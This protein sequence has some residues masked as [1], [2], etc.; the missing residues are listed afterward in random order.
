MALDPGTKRI[1]VALSDELGWTAQPL[2]TFERRTLAQD[3]AHIQQLVREHAV[4]EIV[5]GLPI[6]LNGELGPE[7]EGVKRFIH[8][9]EQSL[10]VP[11][12]AWDERLT[13]K[14]AE[15]LL[16]QA[17]VSRKKRRGVVDRVAAA[18]LLQSY[19]RSL[20]DEQG[21]FSAADAAST[22]TTADSPWPTEG[23]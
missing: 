2:E 19:L 15:Q 12:V 3:V 21:S 22:E 13:T 10:T 17:N 20:S 8:E 14:S 18:I 9:L 23:P 5:M 6:R 4:R 7:A 1:G 16:I 11:V